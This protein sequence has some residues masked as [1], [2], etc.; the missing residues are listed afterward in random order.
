MISDLRDKLE[1]EA[2]TRTSEIQRLEDRMLQ[3]IV[4]DDQKSVSASAATW[5]ASQ[6]AAQ[7]AAALTA[8]R[9]RARTEEV[10]SPSTPRPQEKVAGA[11]QEKLRKKK[12]RGGSEAH[13]DVEAESEKGMDPLVENNVGM[14][15]REAGQ[16][17]ARTEEE[18]AEEFVREM[19]RH[20]KAQNPYT[21]RFGQD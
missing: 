2:S 11:S 16:S 14:Q 8:E 21:V 10:V 12:R 18:E 5:K 1:I 20:P 3:M 7:R 15:A 9:E 13:M 4:R 19:N 6:A 17:R